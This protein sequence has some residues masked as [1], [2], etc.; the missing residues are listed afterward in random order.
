MKTTNRS[1]FTLI[2][3]MVAISI[4]LVVSYMVLSAVN[5]STED[6]VKAGAEILKAQLNGSRDR[7]TFS[8]R[9][10]GVRLLVNPDNP[11]I[12]TGLLVVEKPEYT[13]LPCEKRAK[14]DQPAGGCSGPT[15]PYIVIEKDGDGRLRIARGVG[16][17]W[18][19]L[20]DRG[21]LREGAWMQLGDIGSGLYSSATVQLDLL[22]PG[23]ERL[24]LTRD[25][26]P[27]AANVSPTI[28][29]YATIDMTPVVRPNSDPLEL[30]RGV[31]IDLAS[32]VLPTFWETGGTYSD[33]MDI[34]FNPG[35]DLEK[36]HTS[37]GTIKLVIATRDDIELGNRVETINREDTCRIVTVQLYT[38][39]VFSSEVDVTDT[40]NNDLADDPFNY[41]ELGH[42]V[43]Y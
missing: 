25:F 24:R 27:K 9:Q 33:Q 15:E 36:V 41:S 5:V 17:N 21:L 37:G 38:G 39:R 4:M 42:N 23:S 12:C 19:N 22:A 35:G 40:N 11:K 2:E 1:G 18:N 26:I 34:M 16:T 43:S 6:N 14:A 31:A 10:T 32:S 30:P 13:I 8:G 28:V 7:A 20:R 3:L 29:E